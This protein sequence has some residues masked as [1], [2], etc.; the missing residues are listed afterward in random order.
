MRRLLVTTVALVGIAVAVWRGS[1]PGVPGIE[2]A[3]GA[4][5]QDRGDASSTKDLPAPALESVRPEDRTQLSVTSDAAA[6][7]DA[8]A[9]SIADAQPE[10]TTSLTVI[11]RAVDEHGLPFDAERLEIDAWIVST[12]EE[13]LLQLDRRGDY[14]PLE[15]GAFRIEYRVAPGAPSSFAVTVAHS[16]DPN[17]TDLNAWVRGRCLVANAEA[18]SVNVGDVVLRGPTVLASGI[19][20]DPQDRAVE[21]DVTARLAEPSSPEAQL[22]A[23]RPLARSDVLGRFE[24]RGWTTL[25]RVRLVASHDSYDDAILDD[26]ATG[27]TDVVLHLRPSTRGSLSGQVLVSEP[28]MIIRVRATLTTEDGRDPVE[29]SLNLYSGRFEFRRLAPGA[30][31]LRITTPNG[32]LELASL[33][34]LVVPVGAAC[35]DPRL[36][37]ID[38]RRRA[39]WIRGHAVREDGRVAAFGTVMYSAGGRDG[40]TVADDFGVWS[41]LVPVDASDIEAIEP[42]GTRAPLREGLVVHVR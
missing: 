17:S 12:T 37:P 36:E 3:G 21:A 33:S 6:T 27:A 29:G 18:R 32:P 14:E 31:R 16:A 35:A 39:T 41:L 30:Y 1:R 25:P 7:T 34:H 38:L 23:S 9:V 24:L 26:V 42:D 15:G 22:S 10:P 11:G 2:S 19:V 20:L 13:R 5:L 40:H 8:S 28:D 4:A